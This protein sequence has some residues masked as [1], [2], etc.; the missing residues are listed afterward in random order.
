MNGKNSVPGRVDAGFA[1]CPVQMTLGIMFPGETN[2]ALLS[3]VA[4]KNMWT[5]VSGPPLQFFLD[6]ALRQF[7]FFI[8]SL[9]NYV[10][11]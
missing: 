9:L 8:L 4:V 6:L 11:E 5:L 2:K 1:F 3:T 7:F 10:R